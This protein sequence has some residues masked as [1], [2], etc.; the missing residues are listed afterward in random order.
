[1]DNQ[2]FKLLTDAIDEIKDDVKAMR[3]DM[4]GVKKDIG[5]YKG[6]IGGVVFVLSTV[7]MGVTYLFSSQKS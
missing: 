1:M 6:F 2:A 7:W 5:H 3:V 4:A